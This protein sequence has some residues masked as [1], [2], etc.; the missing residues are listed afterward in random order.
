MSEHA[1]QTSSRTRRTPIR[2]DEVV[3]LAPRARTPGAPE[4][5]P[6][7]PPLSPEMANF[8]QFGQPSQNIRI[9]H[10]MQRI[11]QPE[12]PLEPR[13]EPAHARASSEDM[14]QPLLPDDGDNNGQEPMPALTAPDN[15]SDEEEFNADAHTHHAE[16]GPARNARVARQPAPR[17]PPVQYAEPSK[18]LSY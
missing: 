12:H 17:A 11:Y 14:E 2:P 15:S 8:N 7:P 16:L 1:N 13:E 10:I 9:E 18:L 5:P 6:S 3:S 4:S